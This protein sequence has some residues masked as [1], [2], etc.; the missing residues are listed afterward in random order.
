MS[1]RV[2]EDVLGLQIAV[3]NVEAVKV[4]QRTGNFGGVELGADG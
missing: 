4:A 2:K 1:L 3:H